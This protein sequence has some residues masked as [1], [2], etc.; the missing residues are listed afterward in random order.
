MCFSANVSFG[1][2]VVIATAGV[3]STLKIKLREQIMFAVIPL[4]FALQQVMEG[5]VWLTLTSDN[6]RRWQY[7]PVTTFLF[8]AQVVWPVWAPLSILKIEP[9]PRRRSVL[10]ILCI[11]SLIIAPLQAY[12]LFFYPPTVEVAMY[13]IHYGLD[14]SIPYFG[15]ALNVLY[16]MTTIVPA[17]ISSRKSVVVLG[18]LNL[19]AL[20]VSVVF[21]RPNIVSVWCFFA[22]LISWQVVQ[23]MR[24]MRDEG[25]VEG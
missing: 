8:L 6:Y 20:I 15:V 24:N 18:T 25:R 7:V 21:Y 13:N 4:I 12:R 19:L 9:E 22:A 14:I 16:F 1:A 2:G 17:F 11:C 5:W 10:K 3:V 23:T